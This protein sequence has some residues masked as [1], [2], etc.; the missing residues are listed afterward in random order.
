MAINFKMQSLKKKPVNNLSKTDIVSGILKGD[1]DKFL[2]RVYKQ[3][4]Y[5]LTYS[6]TLSKWRGEGLE[7][8]RL[9]KKSPIFPAIMNDYCN[10][11]IIMVKYYGLKLTPQDF[12]LTIR[13]EDVLS[14]AIYN[15]CSEKRRERIVTKRMPVKQPTKEEAARELKRRGYIPLVDFDNYDK[16]MAHVTSNKNIKGPT[17]YY[18]LNFKWG[19]WETKYPEDIKNPGVELGLKFVGVSGYTR[20][21]TKMDR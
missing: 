6:V 15:F 9:I 7:L 20:I 4:D 19:I 14:D 21:S 3:R 1:L 17:L 8:V 11:H 18:P 16:S 12:K 2:R 5:Q 13:I 10:L